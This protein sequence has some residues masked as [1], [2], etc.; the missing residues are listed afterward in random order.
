MRRIGKRHGAC[1][2]VILRTSQEMFHRFGTFQSPL[3]FALPVRPGAYIPLGYDLLRYFPI[4]PY[5][6]QNIFRLPRLL[7]G[8]TAAPAYRMSSEQALRSHG[9][10]AGGRVS[11]ASDLYL[12]LFAHQ[13]R[14]SCCADLGTDF[15]NGKAGGHLYLFVSMTTLLS[16]DCLRTWT[17]YTSRSRIALD[18]THLPL[19]R[20]RGWA[21]WDAAL[22][23][24]NSVSLRFSLLSLKWRNVIWRYRR[25]PR[26]WQRLDQWSTGLPEAAHN[27]FLTSEWLPEGV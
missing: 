23:R 12:P 20:F 14:D 26:P 17:A 2:V 5:S 25:L 16:V 18:K 1:T 10:S 22:L 19:H 27:I 21:E 8:V 13:F 4:F 11:A 15:P 24:Q 9:L 3:A 7:V 6:P